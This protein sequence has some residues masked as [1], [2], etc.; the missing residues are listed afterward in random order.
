MPQRRAATLLQA[1]TTL[2]ENRVTG[3]PHSIAVSGTGVSKFGQDLPLAMAPLYWVL[4][5]IPHKDKIIM[6]E[7]LVGS[8][9][10]FT[11][12]WCSQMARG[13]C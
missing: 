6:E 10:G 4:L 8:G 5:K 9:E 12:V 11:V 1:T 7:R 2:R 13:V 3:S